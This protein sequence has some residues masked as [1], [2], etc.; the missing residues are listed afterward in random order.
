MK[1]ALLVFGISFALGVLTANAE[2]FELGGRSFQ[3]QG[4]QQ[5]QEQ[6]QNNANT[7]ANDN[8][9]STVV[10]GGDVPR[11]APTAAAPSVYNKV[12][13]RRLSSLELAQQA[14]VGRKG[15]TGCL[16]IV[17]TSAPQRVVDSC[18]N[19]FR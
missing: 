10:N 3:L 8:S 17:A 18:Y 1:K 6:V 7:N 12:V 2:A 4:Q 14:G 16:S 13:K 19:A 15:A 11:T 9:Q 5:S